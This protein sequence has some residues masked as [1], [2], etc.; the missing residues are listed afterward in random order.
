[1]QPE[2]ATPCPG[3]APAH[4][5]WTSLRARAC[6]S[7]I[8]LLALCAATAAA[9]ETI[10]GDAW[11]L[12]ARLLPEV[13]A[14]GEPVILE[15]RAQNVSQTA[16]L[17]HDWHELTLGR[18]APWSC[19]VRAK[20]ND[21]EIKVAMGE[22]TAMPEHRR[23]TAVEPGRLAICRLLVSFMTDMSREGKYSFQVRVVS[24]TEPSGQAL[25]TGVCRTEVRGA[26]GKL[27][28]A[29]KAAAARLL[30]DLGDGRWSVQ[31]GATS[32]LLGMGRQVRPLIEA[33]AKDPNPRVA[34]RARMILESCAEPESAAAQQAPAGGRPGGKA[35]V[36]T[37]GDRAGQ[38]EAAAAYKAFQSGDRRR[39]A[40]LFVRAV[41][42]GSRDYQVWYNAGQVLTLCGRFE[43]ALPYLDACLAKKPGESPLLTA[44]GQCRY[45]LGS[46]DLAADDFAAALAA[47]NTPEYTAMWAVAAARH[48]GSER[49]AKALKQL[50]DLAPTMRG[51]PWIAPAVLFFAGETTEAEFVKAM[52]SPDARIRRERECEGYYY[53]GVKQLLKGDRDSARAA[54]AR[55]VEINVDYFMEPY[56]AARELADL[57]ARSAPAKPP[58]NGGVPGGDAD[59]GGSG[60]DEDF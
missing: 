15:L 51:R 16:Q 24:G 41:G 6:G 48:V 54:F 9:G 58:G 2:N 20:F 14:R 3:P 4:T 49:T 13:A 28:D 27:G 18:G 22:T 44:R 5:A 12:E 55:C 52:S 10:R 42:R 43:E 21:A 19:R 32:Q 60:S 50:S 45:C 35:V 47:R 39:A 33:A 37:S 17:F 53:L 40:D 34:E 11:K 56:F 23:L 26:P 7:V 59:G 46:F 1:M 29:E 36:L 30:G 57:D 8:A 38:A 25:W 31:D